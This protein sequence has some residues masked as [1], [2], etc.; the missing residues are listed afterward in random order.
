VRVE[1]IADESRQIA[2]LAQRSAATQVAAAP[3]QEVRVVPLDGTPAEASRAPAEQHQQEASGPDMAEVQPPQ[4][5]QEPVSGTERIYVQ[6]GAFVQRELAERMQRKLS[7]IG[8]TRVVEAHVGNQ[9]FFRVRLGPA[10]TVE[11]GDRLLDDVIA[12][13]YP[14]ARIVVD[15]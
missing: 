4:L 10:G 7:A 3:S 1:I 15:D 6:A 13:G 8:P 11:R 5:T 12:Y 14:E 9:R 2:A